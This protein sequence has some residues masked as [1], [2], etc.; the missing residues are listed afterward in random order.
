MEQKGYKCYNPIT[1]E[2]RLSRYV[3]FDEL[4]AWYEDKRK[5]KVL[6][7]DCD[8]YVGTNQSE[9]QKSSIEISCPEASTSKEEC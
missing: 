2:V 6:E 8:D 4:R 9:G 1:K 7:E 3:V 5:G